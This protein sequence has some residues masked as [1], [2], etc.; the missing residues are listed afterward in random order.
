M[1]QHAQR[2]SLLMMTDSKKEIVHVKMTDSQTK[3]IAHFINTKIS[4]LE[5][6]KS[7]GME[8][9]TDTAGRYK[10][11]C[12]IHNENTASFTIYPNNSYFCFGCSSGGGVLKFMMDYEHLTYDEVIDRYRGDVD[13]VSDKFFA[14]TLVK[15]LNKSNFNVFKY[16]K[17]TQYQLGIYLRDLMYRDSSKLAK[18]NECFYEMDIFFNNDSI[19]DEKLINDFVDSIMGSVV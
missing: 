12:P 10:M 16:K 11:K 5:L 4:L 14:D 1:T 17:D 13:V 19:T 3:R 9:K 7:H 18:I 6:I 2:I 15:N 8:P